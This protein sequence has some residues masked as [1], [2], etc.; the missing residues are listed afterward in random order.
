MTFIR[1]TVALCAL[2]LGSALYAAEPVQI[3]NSNALWFDQWDGL[4]HGNLRV[5]DPSGKI[6]DYYQKRGT[7][8]F[9]LVGGQVLDGVYRYELRATIGDY[10][11]EEQDSEGSIA[12]DG[13][14]DSGER[15]LYITGSFT[16][17]RGVIVKQPDN[18]E[19]KEKE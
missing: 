16:V 13:D 14:A 4:S 10:V 2:S 17:E 5:A 8:V 19:S 18:D 11:E 6:T 1:T 15:P 7:P 3:H 12:G 9:K